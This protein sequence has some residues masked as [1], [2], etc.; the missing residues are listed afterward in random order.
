M[1]WILVC[2]ALLWQTACTNTLKMGMDTETA[3]QEHTP[4]DLDAGTATG[5]PPALQ[6]ATSTLNLSDA[7][8]DRLQPK[9]KGE[10]RYEC[11]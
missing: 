3:G 4:A 1:L 11:V 9:T 10:R 7:L 2:F 8:I 5:Q 6:T